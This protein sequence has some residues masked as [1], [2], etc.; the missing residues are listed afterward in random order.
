MKKYLGLAALTT[1]AALS[2]TACGGS[3][4]PAASSAPTS[5]G[6]ASASTPAGNADKTLTLWLAGGDTPDA[7]RTYLKDTFK[8][9]TGATLKIEEQA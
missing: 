3:G 7:L 6:S 1:A 2:L 8:S 5:T 4:A 9:K